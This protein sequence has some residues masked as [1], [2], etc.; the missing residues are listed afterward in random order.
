MRSS[1]YRSGFRWAFLS[2]L[3]LAL[4][5]GAWADWGALNMPRGVTEVSN[6]V[7]TLHMR[8][9]YIC[10]AIGAAVFGVM[11][12]SMYLHRKSRGVKPATFHESTSVEIVWTVVPLVIL[13]VMA[14]PAARVLIKMEDFSDSEMSIKVTAYQWRWHYEYMDSGVSFYSQLHPEHNKARQQGADVD[15]AASFPGTDFNGEDEIYLREVDNELVVPVGKK[16]RFLHTAADVIHSW[17][18]HDLAIKKDAIPG[19]INENWARIEE[20]GIYRGKCAELCGRDHGFMPIVVR[21]VPQEEYDSWIA[22]KQ[23]TLANLDAAT[24]RQWSK[25]E[26]VASGKIVYEANCM[27]CHQAEGQGIPGMF[28]A[29]TGSEVATGSIDKHIGTVMHGVEGTMMS[30]FST[31]LSDVD[32]AAVITYQRNALG[33]AMGDTLQPAHIKSLRTDINLKAPSSVAS[34]AD[35]FSTEGVN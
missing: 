10:C 18:V 9:F 21:A 23:Q 6:E 35:T 20:P 17:W 7:Y 11:I 30:Q 15:L 28:P 3:L 1:V 5:L 16:I 33:N 32:I 24:E 12:V 8:I 14:I 34:A 31:V 26:L 25:Q 2:V 4:P 29:I 13:I 19:F 22:E 27:S